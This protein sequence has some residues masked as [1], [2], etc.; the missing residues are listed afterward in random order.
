VAGSSDSPTYVVALAE[1]GVKPFKASDLQ[2]LGRNTLLSDPDVDPVETLDKESEDLA[3]GAR[4]DGVEELLSIPAVDD[5]GVGWDSYP[6]SWEESP[7]PNRLI[8][9]DAWTSM[10]ASWRGAYKELKSKRL[11]SSMKDE[12]Y[13]TDMWRSWSN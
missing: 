1:G 11:A 7:K 3:L 13:L 10:G 4:Y 9:L 2:E 8:L 6:D 12:V 5:P